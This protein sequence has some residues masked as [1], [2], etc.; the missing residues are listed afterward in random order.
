MKNFEI[1][2]INLQLL[3]AME[4]LL[5]E[6]AGYPTGMLDEIEYF[7]EESPKGWL[8]ALDSEEN[9]IGFVRSFQQGEDWSLGE[10]FIKHECPNR[11]EI[12]TSL[13]NRFLTENLFPVGHRLRFDFSSMDA[14]LN[15]MV[16]NLD[17][18]KKSQTFRY[19]ELNVPQLNEKPSEAANISANPKIV[20]EVLSHLHPVSE[21]DAK[22]WLD[23]G[24]VRIQ[25]DGDRIA[26]AA[27]IYFYP[28]SAEINRIATHGDF[29]RQGHAKRLMS[30]ICAELVTRDI[31]KL[32]L[33]VEDIRI[34]AIQCYKSFGF[35]EISEKR[36][37]WHSLYF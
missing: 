2:N 24:S 37:T 21:A 27:Q 17:L 13:I 28:A 15:S 6:S 19:F 5:S 23:S 20:A 9:K 29:L 33:K 1:V 8:I 31:R 35:K 26:S 22:N 14:D 25:M 10:L 7:Q 16:E 34:P 4:S 36:Q 18:H 32:F 30:R 11:K 3:S 12:A